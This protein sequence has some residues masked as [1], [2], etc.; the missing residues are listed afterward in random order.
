MLLECFRESRTVADAIHQCALQ[1]KLD[2]AALLKEA[3]PLLRDCYNSRFLVTA[4]SDDAAR[5]A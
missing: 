3:F 2:P 5:S 1:L 4:D